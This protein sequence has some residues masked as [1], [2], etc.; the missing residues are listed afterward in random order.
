MVAL[1]LRK[2][3]SWGIGLLV[4]LSWD[5]SGNHH[6]GGEPA[7]VLGEAVRAEYRSTQGTFPNVQVRPED[8]FSFEPPRSF[9]EEK[10]LPSLPVPPSLPAQ[11]DQLA[12]P[13]EG[14]VA[15]HFVEEGKNALE[16]DAFDQ[17]RA[18]LERAIA[19]APF[20]PYSY[21]FLGRVAFAQ[22]EL[23]QAL[24]FLQKAELLFARDDH[25]WLGET[26]CLRGVVA[27]DLGD[28]TQA[29]VAYQRCLRFTPHN[30]RALSALARLSPED[31]EA[32]EF[33]FRDS[34]PE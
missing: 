31:P 5:L 14:L 2:S 6:A 18:L 3:L 11:P 27:E 7:R 29:R 25:A 4:F 28:Y 30:L 22:G 21:H 8:Q 12:F 16:R 13:P 9:R 15:L 20:Q 17:A 10:P 26:T 19:I 33:L 1:I 34:V 23:E 24:A 32:S